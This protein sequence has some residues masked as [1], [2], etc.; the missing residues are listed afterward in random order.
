MDAV[1]VAGDYSKKVEEIVLTTLKLRNE[2]AD[3]KI[4]IFSHWDTI[5]KVIATA[6]AE[7]NVQFRT[8]SANF[9]KSIDEFKVSVF[10]FVIVL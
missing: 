2:D 6:L 1:A 9:H 4:I 8:Q 7:N 10:C 3:V 5:L